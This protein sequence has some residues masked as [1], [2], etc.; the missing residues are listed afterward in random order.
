MRILLAIAL[1]IAAAAAGHWAALDLLPQRVM[2][3]AMTAISENAGGMNQWRHA[4]RITPDN[5]NVVKPSPDLA[6]SACI[7]D[8]TRGPVRLRVAPWEDYASLS[9]YAADTDN[10][11]VINDREMPSGGYEAVLMAAGAPRPVTGLPIIESPGPRGV[12]LIRRLAPDPF[13][14]ERSDRVRRQDICA[15]F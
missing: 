12:V 5:R 6:Y 10:F 3:K 2:E 15:T 7:Y 11:F 1:F 14:F 8:L 9:L 13:S 4:P